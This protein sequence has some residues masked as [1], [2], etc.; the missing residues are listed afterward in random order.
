MISPAQEVE[1][2]FEPMHSTA[3]DHAPACGGPTL[4][5]PGGQSRFVSQ[6]RGETSA[7][8][9]VKETDTRTEDMHLPFRLGIK[10]GREHVI[11]PPL[12]PHPHS[13]KRTEYATSPLRKYVLMRLLTE[14]YGRLIWL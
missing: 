8:R 3:R 2:D 12:H 9:R 4:G 5:G 11:C 7:T 10:R 13:W 14:H 1:S 6:K